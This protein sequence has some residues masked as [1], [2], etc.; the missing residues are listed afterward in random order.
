LTWR[1]VNSGNQAAFLANPD[2]YGPKFGGYDP[3]GLTQGRA[4]A[5]NP[6]LWLIYRQRL[7]FFFS[8]E[9]LETFK[10]DPAGQFGMADGAWPRVMRD[11]VQ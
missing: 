10:T 6:D 11:L 2:V 5:G 9:N 3:I 4:V 8:R 7:F 1:F